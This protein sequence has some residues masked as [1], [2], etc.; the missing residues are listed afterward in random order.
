MTI[1]SHGV[2]SLVEAFIALR[3]EKREI[4]RNVALRVAELDADMTVLTAAISDYCKEIGADSIRTAHGTIIRSVKKKYRT[5]DWASIY[6]FIKEHDAF[7]LLTKSIHQSNMKEF[8]E[9][10]P[11]LH[12]A[13]LNVDAEYT[14]TIRKKS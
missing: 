13:G 12:P 1:E 10:N 6:S 4:E 11:D 14:I 2:D 3:D 9:S 8:L 5:N 7:E